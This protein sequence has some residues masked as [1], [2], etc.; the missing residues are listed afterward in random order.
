M[1]EQTSLVIFFTYRLC[2]SKSLDTLT[3]LT[4][5]R[6]TTLLL[7]QPFISS[8]STLSL[9]LFIP[10]SPYYSFLLSFS[11]LLSL[12]HSLHTSLILSILLSHSH[13]TSPLLVL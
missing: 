4:S 11:L 2:K 10:L 7:L 13:Y 1:K 5:S 12:S 9:S 6:L 3:L 8:S